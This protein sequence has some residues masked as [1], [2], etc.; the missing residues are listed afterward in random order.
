MPW[1]ARRIIRQQAYLLCY[2]A[3]PGQPEWS[4]SR[5]SCSRHADVV[6]ETN[7]QSRVF[8]STGRLQVLL[9]CVTSIARH[10]RRCGELPPMATRQ[11][12][13]A[14]PLPDQELD[15]AAAASPD[16]Q[17]SPHAHVV[18]DRSSQSA[19]GTEDLSTE[20]PTDKATVDVRRTPDVSL[21]IKILSLVDL[22]IDGRGSPIRAASA[23]LII[24]AAASV[25]TVVVGNIP[26][27]GNPVVC[28]L[29]FFLVLAGGL[30][31]HKRLR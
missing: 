2:R 1:S 3:H 24:V 5:G 10:Y 13:M 29:V 21:V 11:V 22:R 9:R 25:A 31:G 19:P 30:L 26:S 18:P 6:R 27:I 23:Y 4:S 12:G 28:A 16:G 20:N 8:P 15:L 7:Q 17:P 14:N